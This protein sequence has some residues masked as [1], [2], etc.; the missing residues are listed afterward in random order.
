MAGMGSQKIP[1]FICIYTEFSGAN[2][3]LLLSEDKPVKL[4]NINR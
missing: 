2:H 4:V 1:F 3:F